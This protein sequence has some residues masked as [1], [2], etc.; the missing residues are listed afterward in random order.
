M[1]QK[2]AS[3]TVL[4][5][6]LVLPSVASADCSHKDFRD[7]QARIAAIVH[8]EQ[9]SD[10]RKAHQLQVQSHAIADDLTH[11]DII[12][13]GHACGELDDL[14]ANAAKQHP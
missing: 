8:Q 13:L 11:G 9:G 2:I 5:L 6:A 7:K 4:M 10:A 12:A 14:I 1:F 3:G